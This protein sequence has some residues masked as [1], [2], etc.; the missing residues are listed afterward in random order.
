VPSTLSLGPCSSPA[1]AAALAEMSALA[2][3]ALAAQVAHAAVLGLGKCLLERL[4]AGQCVGTHSHRL[5]RRV[6]QQ[7]ELRQ[8]LQVEGV[9][10]G[11]RAGELLPRF[12]RSAT[13]G[14]TRQDLLDEVLADQVG[15]AVAFARP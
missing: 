12:Q 11:A 4:R 8:R 14:R 2:L 5:C 7:V 10:V 13:E 9:E 1:A 3:Q 6:A 15:R